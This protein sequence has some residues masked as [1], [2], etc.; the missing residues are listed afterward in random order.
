MPRSGYGKMLK[1]HGI[2]AYSKATL[3]F[4]DVLARCDTIK[5][6]RPVQRFNKGSGQW[7]VMLRLS[8]VPVGLT[9]RFRDS[10]GCYLYYIAVQNGVLLQTCCEEIAR[11]VK[12]WKPDITVR[13]DPNIFP[14]RERVLYQFPRMF[15]QWKAIKTG[16]RSKMTFRA[17]NQARYS[18]PEK[19]HSSTQ[20]L[21]MLP[22]LTT[23]AYG[24]TKNMP[25]SQMCT[26]SIIKERCDMT[27]REIMDV[28]A[29]LA[30]WGVLVPIANGRNVIWRFQLVDYVPD[31]ALPQQ[32]ANQQDDSAVPP[33]Q[34]HEAVEQPL[35][36]QLTDSVS[37]GIS[38]PPSGRD[39]LA[40]RI[41][42]SLSYI[43]KASV[44]ILTKKG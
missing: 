29:R 32:N 16:L 20:S 13:M 22:R 34:E 28:L 38:I 36:E 30:E 35:I 33:P 26:D 12:M 21:K 19:P 18:G 5:R 3:D 25:K 44:R 9:A 14:Q 6:F 15:P 10:D 4:C 42:A 1:G 23:N 11:C 31:F 24:F 43:L 41:T 27:Y 7:D 39:S 37:C 40:Q 17:Y 8:E 2:K